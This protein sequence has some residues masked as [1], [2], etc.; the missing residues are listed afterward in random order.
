M[1]SKTMD[2]GGLLNS[3][4]LHEL[5]CSKKVNEAVE[6]RM[7]GRVLGNVFRK[8]IRSLPIQFK[9]TLTTVKSGNREIN[10]K[11]STI[12]KLEMKLA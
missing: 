11:T 8:E 2:K 9:E 12:I 4:A 6:E 5:R 7:T 1:E 3:D 10:Y